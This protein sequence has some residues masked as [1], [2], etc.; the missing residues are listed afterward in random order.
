L[1]AGDYFIV[2]VDPSL[3]TAWQDPKFL[4]RAAA[5]AIRVSLAWDESKALDLSKVRIR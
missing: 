4:E 5:V 2:A 1:P 3:V